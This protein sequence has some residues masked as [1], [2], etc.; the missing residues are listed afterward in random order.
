MMLNLRHFPAVEL[1]L[2]A[3]IFNQIPAAVVETIRFN[4]TTNIFFTQQIEAHSQNPGTEAELGPITALI[5]FAAAGRPA[6]SGSAS[7][8]V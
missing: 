8:V 1:C 3:C 6:S 4:F 5:V 2:S 7:T